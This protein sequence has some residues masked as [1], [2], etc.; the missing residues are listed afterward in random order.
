MPFTTVTMLAALAFTAIFTAGLIN[1]LMGPRLVAILGRRTMPRRDHVVVVGLGQVGLRLC[2]MLREL[3]VPVVAVERDLR[4][5]QRR[6]RQALRDPGRDR[7]RRQP[8]RAEPPVAAARPRAGR[9]HLRR[10][11]EHLDGRRRRCRCARTC[12][13]SCAPAAATSWT[14]RARCF[15]SAS[16]A[17]STSSAAR[18]WPP[19][20]SART[21]TEA[22]PCGEEIYITRADGAV[23]PFAA[24]VRAAARQ[25][26]ATTLCTVGRHDATSD[27]LAPASPVPKIWPEVV[28]KYS[29]SA[30]PSPVR[31]ERVAQDRQVGVLLGQP[32]AE[33]RPARAGVARRE[34]PRPPVGGDAIAP[35]RQRDD[36]RAV[37]I[38]GID[39]QR[40]TRSP[41]AARRRCPSSSRPRRRSG[42]RRRETA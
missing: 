20:R 9:R 35:S 37:R 22:F 2:L 31:A 6:A 32:L 38:G 39:R 18:C 8:R 36:E 16:C 27:Q 13:R 28:P 33:R 11:R 15:A 34:D 10:D 25:L 1:R 19:R 17:T 42:R 5:R 3:G 7:R 24:H 21:A 40:E 23:E 30:G 12:R 26:T 14:R 29:S 41:T 4:G